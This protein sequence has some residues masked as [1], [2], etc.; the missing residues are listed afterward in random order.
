VPGGWIVGI[1]VVFFAAS[2]ATYLLLSA[3][4]EAWRL[5][6]ER[7]GRAAGDRGRPS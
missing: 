4:G 1:Q 5:R 2:V 6:G 3:V 7:A